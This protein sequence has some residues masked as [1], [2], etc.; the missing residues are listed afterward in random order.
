MSQPIDLRLIGPVYHVS[1]G[2]VTKRLR[3]R[4]GGRVQ[5]VGKTF[6]LSNGVNAWIEYLDGT[7]NVSIR[8]SYGWLFQY[9]VEVSK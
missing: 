3:C 8:D 6:Q 4:V 7:G 5:W 2:P 1:R 9:Q